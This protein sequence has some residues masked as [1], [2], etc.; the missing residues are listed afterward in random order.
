MVIYIHDNV[1]IV[2]IDILTCLSSIES[3]KDQSTII[4]ELRGLY[5]ASNGSHSDPYFLLSPRL[6]YANKNYER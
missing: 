5:D 3:H 6:Y 4:S 2:D 1:W